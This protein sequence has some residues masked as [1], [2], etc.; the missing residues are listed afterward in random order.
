MSLKDQMER[1]SLTPAEVQALHDRYVDSLGAIEALNVPL[2]QQGRLRQYAA[3]LEVLAHQAGPKALSPL[4]QH[5]LLREVS[6]LNEIVEFLDGKDPE[7]MGRLRVLAKDPESPA[8]PSQHS[9]G[10]DAQFELVLRSILKKSG[11]EPRL[12][13]PDLWL[14][15]G[16][17]TLV[18][19][20]KR[21]R[22]NSRVQDRVRKAIKQ[23][24]TSGRPGL[25]A[26]S[27]DHVVAP[28][29]AFSSAPNDMT[30]T[31]RSADQFS[32]WARKNR[33][34]LKMRLE[35]TPVCGTLFFMT[36]PIVSGKA[37]THETVMN[38]STLVV[39]EE[40][41][42]TVELVGKALDD[43]SSVIVR[44]NAATGGQRGSSKNAV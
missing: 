10:R 12:G 18:I 11:L 16:D 36:I 8:V 26:L 6:E 39:P 4:E 24:R 14:G 17:A 22:R 42:G 9:P 40:V 35:D 43:T 19:E 30:A 29:P 21:P 5:H 41:A 7:F 3:Q 44:P 33:L 25:I 1:P 23:V 34:W 2:H 37:L 38:L 28:P 20:A 27:L 31:I 32:D 13:T 15:D